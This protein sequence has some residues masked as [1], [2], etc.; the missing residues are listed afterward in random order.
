MPKSSPTSDERIAEAI[1]RIAKAYEDCADALVL[2]GKI[3]S[4]HLE[5]AYPTIA[6]KQP[7]T[8]FQAKYK[9]PEREDS[10]IPFEDQVE[11]DTRTGTAKIK[12]TAITSGQ[13]SGSS[14]SRRS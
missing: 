13:K 4:E 10:T 8:V 14:T 3:G 7:V 6:V 2:L 5:R 11:I 9:T 1:E 12:A